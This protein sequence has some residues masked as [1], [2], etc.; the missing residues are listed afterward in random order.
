MVPFI[1]SVNAILY[2]EVRILKDIPKKY[3]DIRENF[4]NNFLKW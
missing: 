1:S 3:K 4:V 2:K